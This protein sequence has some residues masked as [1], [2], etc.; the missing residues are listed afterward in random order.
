M[1]T[2]H[3]TPPR[4]STRGSGRSGGLTEP[5]IASAGGRT[6]AGGLVEPGGL[7]DPGLIEPTGLPGGLEEPVMRTS[8]QS[9]THAVSKAWV[10]K[11]GSTALRS[12]GR[13]T[14]NLIHRTHD[15]TQAH[16]PHRARQHPPPRLVD[17]RELQLGAN[18][19]HG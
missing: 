17:L 5:T 9:I 13:G 18:R 2:F 19:S 8:T 12:L 15:E 7:I 4:P 16:D 3:V 14:G 10:E 6:E 11:F 1:G